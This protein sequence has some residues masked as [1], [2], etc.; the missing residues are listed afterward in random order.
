MDS[1]EL[2]DFIEGLYDENEN[3]LR[4]TYRQKKES[5]DELLKAIAIIM[6]SYNIVDG[7]MSLSRKD[8]LKESNNIK[9]LIKSLT[10]GDITQMQDNTNNILKNTA[11][12]VFD[13]YSYNHDLK[14]VEKIIKDGFK[15][16]HFSDRIWDNEQ[17]VANRLN[18]QCQD[19]LQGKINVNQIKN[20]IEKTYNTSAYNA[21]RLVETEVSRCSNQSFIRFCNETGVEKVRYNS[22]LDAN[23][24]NDCSQYNGRIYDLDKAPELPRHPLCRCFYEISD[25]I[26][27]REN[28]NRKEANQ[29]EF[30]KLSIPLQKRYIKRIAKKYNLNIRG[31]NIKI[32]R[33]SELIDTPFL[34]ST[35]Y[36]DI[37]RIDLFPNAFKNEEEL[38]RTVIHEK[39]HVL[40]L[41]KH[42]KKYCQDNLNLMEKQAYKYEELW[43][44]IL[45]KRVK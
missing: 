27:Y 31:L 2:Q 10:L 37:G 3:G 25:N 16:K 33:S 5:R 32:Q 45:K 11:E 26:L 18:K 40:Q 19:F 42:G 34:G 6:L 12:S 15:G 41:R 38:I 9:K 1:K 20:D 30:N 43:Y 14:D 21:K 13:F 23:T 8:F 7:V 44:N 24:C 35:D 4:D 28:L 22:V 36:D 29:G 17:A 39:C